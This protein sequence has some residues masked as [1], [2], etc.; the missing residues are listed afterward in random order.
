MSN[1]TADETAEKQPSERRQFTMDF[2]AKMSTLETI[3]ASS[4][5]PVITSEKIC[6]SATD[7]TIETP[8]I[9]GQTLI[10]WISG[11]ATGE[12]Y[13]IEAVITTSTGAILEGDGIMSIGDK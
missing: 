11:G 6:G 2:A 7:L 3:V 4:P 1:S 9:S 8:T 5:A 13:R 12:R 10:M